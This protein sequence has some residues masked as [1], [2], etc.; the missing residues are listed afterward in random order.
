MILTKN[1]CGLNGPLSS[2]TTDDELYDYFIQNIY[3]G[4]LKINGM[5]I[6]VF[7]TPFEDN[8]MQGFFHLTT[9]TQKKFG[10]KIRM[11]EPRAY[12]IN[13]VVPMINNY[14]KC[15]TCDDLD[16]GKIKIW[17]APYKMTKRTKLLYSDEQY[18]YIIILEKKNKDMYIVSSYLIDEP[19]YLEK[20]LEEYEKYK[21]VA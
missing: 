10:M 5:N 17:S 14:V 15:P 21:K 4:D 19:G 20:V 9:K 12:F 18:S 6:K 13:Y 8:R 1:K 16:C 2:T 3:Y 7:T 11:K